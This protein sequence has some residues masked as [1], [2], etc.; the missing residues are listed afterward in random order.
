MIIDR[1]ICIQIPWHFVSSEPTGDL[2]LGETIYLVDIF[3]AA[4]LLFV[5]VA[6][7]LAS[8]NGLIACL[9]RLR[10]RQLSR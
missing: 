3:D 8:V 5:L 9:R 6:L 2:G 1:K 10:S 7:S 4:A